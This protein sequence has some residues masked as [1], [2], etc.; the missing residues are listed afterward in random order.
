MVI[1]TDQLLILDGKPKRPHPR[2]SILRDSLHDYHILTGDVRCVEFQCV[3]PIFA[4]DDIGLPVEEK[5]VIRH[6]VVDLVSCVFG[7]VEDPLELQ[8]LVVDHNASGID[9]E[10]TE[11]AAVGCIADDAGEY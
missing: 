5:S 2:S 4:G 1:T 7:L 8:A 6:A 9:F 11:V 10:I 3:I